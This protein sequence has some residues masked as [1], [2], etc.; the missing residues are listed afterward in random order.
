[1]SRY[2][3]LNT[4]I[5]EGIVAVIRAPNS[6]L[7][8]DVAEAL[9]AGGITVMEITFTVPQATQ[10]LEEMV[11]RVGDRALVGAGTILDPETARTAILHG[12]EFL[13]SP[14]TN[15]D[16][17]RM[18]H[19]YDKLVMPGAHTPTE[20]LTAWEAGADVI[21]IFPSDISGPTHLK[22]LRGPLPQVLM[23]PTGGVNLDTA[24]DFLKAGA[25]ALG[26]GSSLVEK[27]AVASGNLERIETLARQY[28][29]IVRDTR[30]ALQA[31][32]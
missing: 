18:A 13:V 27:D 10:V 22:A 20:V 7:L 8:V 26:I 30:A 21:K 29:Q 32:E 14:A 5:Q 3:D 2:E 11:K 31:A 25:C 16:V 19:R 12:A 9:L 28:V 23:M 4:V 17:I 1:M 24:A 15:L 6:E